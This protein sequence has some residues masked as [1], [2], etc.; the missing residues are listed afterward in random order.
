MNAVGYDAMAIGNHEPDFSTGELRDWISG[1]KFPVLA[2]K[3]TDRASGKLF[4]QP[5]L[6]RTVGGVKV[7]H[8]RFGVSQHSAH[9]GE[10]RM[11]RNWTSAPAADAAR[12]YLPE[13]KREGA[14]IIVALTHLGLGADRK[15]AEAVPGIDVIVGG[16]SHNRMNDA[17]QVGST[18]IVQA[19]A[20]GSDVGRL[21]L[22]IKDG[23]IT[24]HA[25]TLI[26]LDNAV[27]S[28][29]RATAELIER[30]EKPY[31]AELDAVVGEAAETIPRA[32]TLA[33][34]AARKR[35][36][37]SPVDHLF[38]TILREQTGSDIALL[39]GV[40]YGVALQAGPITAEQLR[41]LLPHD[42]KV[43]TMTLTGTQIRSI[44]EQTLRQHLQRRSRNQGGRHDSDERGRIHV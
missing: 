43:V 28:S 11:S 5:Y 19:G 21:D 34:Q 44:F 17:L 18:L 1:A 36:E 33:G 39:P 38:A 7:G 13:M 24:H 31:R 2:G 35:D 42:G 15:L 16:H 32:Q 25:R 23:R 27:V 29:D 41:N 30:I 12:S 37:P 14:Q 9:D 4:T 40:G 20:H 26:T 3:L 10:R 8:P 22:T 6:L